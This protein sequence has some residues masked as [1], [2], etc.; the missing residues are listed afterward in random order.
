M[1]ITVK[2]FATLRENR[3]KIMDLE[4]DAQMTPEQIC[5]MLDIPLEEVAITMVNGR[6]VNM[7]HPLMPSDVLALFPPVGGG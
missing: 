3:D 5:L 1:T 4:V 6:S 2:L 7:N